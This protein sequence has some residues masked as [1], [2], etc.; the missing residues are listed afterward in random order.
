[1]THQDTDPDALP[2][3]AHLDDLAPNDIRPNPENPR[4]HFHEPAMDA[5]AASVDEVGVLV[6]IS[7]YHE[8]SQDLPPYV[9]IDGE[10]RWRVAT[11][12]ARHRIPAIV[13]PPPDPIQNLKTMFNIHMVREDWDDMPTARAV[14]KYSDRTGI[15]EINEL[16]EK[17]GLSV[18]RLKRLVFANSLPDEY[19]D[20][21]ENGTVPSNFFYELKRNVLDLLQQDR[22]AIYARHGE[23]AILRAFVEKRLSGATRNAVELRNM[24]P[25]IRTAAAEAV[26]PQSTSDLDHVIEALITDPSKTIQEAYEET[27]EMVVEAERFIRQSQLVVLRLDRVLA[28]ANDDTERE[29]VLLAVQ[30]LISELE[31]RLSNWGMQRVDG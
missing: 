10:R 12:L 13:M 27:V 31:A 18:E 1:M 21:I 7:V 17:T 23:A 19:K 11:R 30:A 24:R 22:P 28:K 4:Q 9:L 25:I 3:G 6:P 16:S 2:A 14:A 5:L 15:T 29:P 8:P 20:L 26:D